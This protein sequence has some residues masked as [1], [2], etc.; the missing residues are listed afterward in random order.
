MPKQT[1][2]DRILQTAQD[3]FTSK[4]FANASVRE[5]CER[6]AITPPTLYYHFGDKEGLFRAVV[7]ETLN[8][9]SFHGALCQ[10][11]DAA[12]DPQA[13]LRAYVHTYLTQFPTDL[14]N[15]GLHLQ[16]ST[17]LDETSLREL[18]AGI[19]DVYQLT[20]S[21]LEGGVAAGA[22]RAVDVDIAASCLMG[23]VDSFVRAHVYLGAEYDLDH[24]TQVIVDLLMRGLRAS[25]VPVSS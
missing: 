6:A 10:A 22:F 7:E 11:V 21:L 25:A 13:K 14:L 2:R 5:I 18:Q 16:N 4:G 12:P 20:V 24:V 23:M 9:D 19:A 8:L 3:L 17:R 15:P 1:A